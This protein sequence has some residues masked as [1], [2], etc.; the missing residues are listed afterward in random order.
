MATD[1]HSF[2]IPDDMIEECR[3]ALHLAPDTQKSTVVRMA[4]ALLIALP[5]DVQDE[6]ILMAKQGGTDLVKE[7]RFKNSRIAT[8]T[9]Q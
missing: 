2:I 6:M 4:L 8:F 9:N 1:T 7:A 5:A 3:I